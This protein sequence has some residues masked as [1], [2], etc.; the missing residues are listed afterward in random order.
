M[1]VDNDNNNNNSCRV[2]TARRR[3]QGVG[4]L[5]LELPRWAIEA[6]PRDSIGRECQISWDSKYHHPILVMIDT[7][8]AGIVQWIGPLYRTC[9]RAVRIPPR[10]QIA[11][12]PDGDPP[13]TL[14]TALDP[15]LDRYSFG[16][17]LGI[18]EMADMAEVNPGDRGSKDLYVISL[19][20]G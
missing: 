7:T 16:L 8:L 15:V 10:D 12:F 2:E 18:A 6:T 20:P 1:I 13:R 11:L 3:S 14:T 19:S 4:G 17:A 5:K 9:D